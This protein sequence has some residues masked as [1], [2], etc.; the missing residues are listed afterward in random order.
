ML[1]TTQLLFDVDQA[2]NHSLDGLLVE[3]HLHAFD[4]CGKN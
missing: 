3:L 1:N 2:I 4:T